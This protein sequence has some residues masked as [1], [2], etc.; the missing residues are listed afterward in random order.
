MK[1]KTY[2][3]IRARIAPARANI[4]L[5]LALLYWLF[6]PYA[7]YAILDALSVESMSVL[8]YA[9]LLF[10]VR[11]GPPILLCLIFA[12]KRPWTTLSMAPLSLKNVLYIAVI[13]ASLRVIEFLL[14]FGSALAF[15]APMHMPQLG[16]VWLH[17]LVA[18]VIAVI[19]EECLFRGVLYSEYQNQRVSIAKTALATGL[20]F[21]LIHSGIVSIAAS[22]ILGILWAYLLYY[23][24]S[25]WAPILSHA[26]YNALW[27]M[28]PAFHI[29]NQVEYEA[30][31]PTFV[32]I[33]G[34]AALIAVP[35]MVVCT[36]KFWAENRRE[37]EAVAGES[38]VFRWSYWVLIAVMLV[39]I[40]LFRI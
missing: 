12:K 11:F 17:L 35:A 33:L 14:E 18:V 24:R 13:T 23:T 40:A 32:L 1:N 25:I 38:K 7:I 20:F 15:S 28:H 29:E 6:T 16:P 37:M 26:I 3:A 19:Y 10:T 27:Q 5:L 36:I 30:F 2:A 22:A 31:L 8:A 21:G 34:I 9:A 39:V 4:V